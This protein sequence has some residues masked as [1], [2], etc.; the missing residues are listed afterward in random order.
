VP[1]SSEAEARK[2]AAGYYGLCTAVDENL[3]RLL[4]EIDSCGLTGD[5]I[6]VFT[7]DHGY[8]LGSHG[9]DEIDRP[10][11]EASKIPLIIRF[12]RLLKARTEHDA[13]ISNVDYAPTLLSLCGVTPIEGMQGTDL[14]GWLTGQRG[15]QAPTSIFAEGGLGSPAEWRMVVSGR[16]KLAV[17]FRLNPTHLYH[18]GRDPYELRNMVTDPSQSR[19]RDEMLTLLRRRMSRTSDQVLYSPPA[20]P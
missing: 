7:S 19:K 9:L 10:Y 6:V 15:S 8:T 4:G 1:A 16:D 20:N 3:G 11:E 13:L 14:S 5:T 2:N 12:P 17:D 18:L